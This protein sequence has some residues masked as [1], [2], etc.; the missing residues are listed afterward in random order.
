MG[1]S[2]ADAPAGGGTCPNNVSRATT[3]QRLNFST[4]QEIDACGHIGRYFLTRLS[5]EG[6]SEG[7]APIGVLFG[8]NG[9]RRKISSVKVSGEKVFRRW[10]GFC[11]AS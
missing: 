1:L 6:R 4:R 7:G 5:P 8:H 2:A 10:F 11:E 9:G 3:C